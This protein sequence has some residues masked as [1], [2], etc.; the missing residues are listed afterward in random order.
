MDRDLPFH[1]TRRRPAVAWPE[2]TG[3]TS[4]EIHRHARPRELWER[5]TELYA[6]ETV[7]AD[8]DAA[9]PPAEANLILARY[10]TVRAVLH[11]V[12][13][14]PAVAPGVDLAAARDHLAMVSRQR[15]E[16]R[17]LA[18]VLA[19]VEAC[20]GATNST[21]SRLAAAA[22]AANRAGHG[23][24]AFALWKAGW[25]QATADRWHVQAGRIALA[26]ASAARQAGAM[27]ADRFWARRARVQL[28]RALG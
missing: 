12:E 3:P 14:G 11:A 19:S 23:N 25:D 28:R 9:T 4:L 27:R 26:I 1:P 5:R 22:A 20:A 21:V 6:G 15:P 10:F 17:W 2:R 24:G 7:L 8:L 18:A 13:A 16:R